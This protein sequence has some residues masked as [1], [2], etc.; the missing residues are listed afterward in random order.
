M[1]L[2]DSLKRDRKTAETVTNQ[3]EEPST[4]E[5][6]SYEDSIVIEDV[7]VIES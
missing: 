1:G 6:S 7:E 3:T 2:F 5:D 4:I